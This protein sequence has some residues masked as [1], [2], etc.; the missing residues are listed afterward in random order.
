[1]KLLC[2]L[3]VVATVVATVGG[4]TTV[5]LLDSSENIENRECPK[6]CHVKYDG[7][8]HGKKCLQLLEG[9][10]GT[11][12]T[13]GSGINTKI[14][15]TDVSAEILEDK[16]IHGHLVTMR[17]DFQDYLESSISFICFLRK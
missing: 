11:I 13:T 3:S 7:V 2:L 1:M 4:G 15:M 6:N 10:E 14:S 5:N 16:T 9:L 17:E 12:V 8:L